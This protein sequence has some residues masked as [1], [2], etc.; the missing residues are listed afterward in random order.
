[1]KR[2]AQNHQFYILVTFL[3]VMSSCVKEM[4]FNGV[5]DITLE[6]QMKIELL[7]A[8]I[9]QEDMVAIFE[10]NLPPP[11]GYIPEAAPPG[12]YPF[13]LP[14]PIVKPI[15]LTSEERILKYLVDG[16]DKESGAATP[17][18]TFT[19][20]NTINSEFGIEI[21]LLDKDKKEINISETHGESSISASVGGRIVESVVSYSYDAAD[22]K[23]AVEIAIK[24]TM[25]PNEDLYPDPNRS[26][27]INSNGIFNFSYDTSE[28]LP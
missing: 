21:Y 24:F 16:V 13:Q 11:I 22:I 18:L 20:T 1:M 14:N 19:F 7:K 8:E 15:S 3:M 9:T 27:T 6:P 23:K 4:D 10:D 25:D 12:F 26:L 2:F 28:G 17:V 5:K